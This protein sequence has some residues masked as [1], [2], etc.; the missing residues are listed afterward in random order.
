MVENSKMH[1]ERTTAPLKIM[2]IIS[3][4][5]GGDW[6]PLLSLAFG[7]KARGHDVLMVCD[8][9]TKAAVLSA[10]LSTLCLPHKFNL[11]GL[12]NPVLQRIFSTGEPLTSMTPNPLQE[13]AKKTAMYVEK[14]L[15][16]WKPDCILGSLL[17]IESG[18][19][20]AERFK[21]P[22]CFVNPGF[23]FGDTT[24]RPRKMDLSYIGALMY[25]HWLLPP[26]QEATLVLHAT[27]P[28]FDNVHASLPS[29]HFYTG[30]LFWEMP[31][32]IPA[33]LN[34]P[35]PPWVLIS[36]STAP[37]VEEIKIVQAS[38]GALENQAVRILVT[39]P[40]GH[41]QLPFPTLS[42]NVF[43][44]RYV[45]H[46]IALQVSSLAICHAGH[47]IVIKSIYQGTPMVLVPW[48][49]DQPGVASRAKAMG[50]ASVVNRR[51]CNAATLQRAIQKTM[52]S[53]EII[54]RSRCESRR[55]KKM[56]SLAF[57][58]TRLEKINS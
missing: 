45:P 41:E 15:G 50:V 30:P 38:L 12:F 8:E 35:G 44:E 7:M 20:M 27:D 31:A 18:R 56:D 54:L 28:M 29:N 4:C 39:L 53:P 55:L 21:C 37:Q 49:R 9:G 23:H 47:G 58:C 33:Y 13:W 5:G 14:K 48:G 16:K 3:A 46:S 19:V 36:L 26:L 11:S 34:E 22:W 57:A 6:P 42:D 32:R 10:G 2:G 25:E 40:P 52:A 24:A 1:P 17:C 43:M 51:D